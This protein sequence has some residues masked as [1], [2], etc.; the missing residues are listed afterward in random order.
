[1]FGFSTIY[2]RHALM[3]VITVWRG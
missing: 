1:M 3:R 2:L